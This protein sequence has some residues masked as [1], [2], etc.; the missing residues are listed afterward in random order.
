MILMP[1]MFDVTA[2]ENARSKRNELEL[3]FIH[4]LLKY[5]NYLLPYFICKCIS[6]S[7]NC[8]TNE[9]G[10]NKKENV[11]LKVPFSIYVFTHI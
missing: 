11:N 9:K 8:K 4:P 6:R 10:E 5:I 2:N 1:Q 3:S 7:Q